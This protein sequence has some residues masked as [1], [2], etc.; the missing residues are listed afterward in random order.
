M[1]DIEDCLI[2]ILWLVICLIICPVLAF[3]GGYIIGIILKIFLGEQICGGLA[4]LGFHITPNTIPLLCGTL[5]ALFF[6]FSY[7]PSEKE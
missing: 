2:R 7:S 3:L 6:H 5:K 1:N 4:L